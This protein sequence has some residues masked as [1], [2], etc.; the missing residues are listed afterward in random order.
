[1]PYPSGPLEDSTNTLFASM[2]V[3]RRALLSVSDKSGIVDFARQL[4]GLGVQLISTGG[5][6]RTLREA[7]LDVSDVSQIT[8]FP[9]MMDGRVKTLHPVIHGGLLARLDLATHV[10]AMK[11]YGIES[12]D[13]VVVNLYPFQQTLEKEGSTH[14]EIVEHID[15]GGPAM[16]RSSA[17][18]YLFTAIVTSPLRYESIL[19]ELRDGGMT[20]SDRTR[21]ELAAEAFTHTARYDSAISCYLNGLIDDGSLIGPSLAISLPRVQSLR[22]GENPHQDGGLY[23]SFNEIFDQIHG[24]ELSYNNILDIDAATRAVLEFD[25]PTV[26]IVKHTNPCGVARAASLLKAWELAFATDTKSPFGGIIAVNRSLDPD[27]ASAINEIFTEVVIA[28]EFPEET[29]AVLRR[30]RDR[31][32]I[33]ARYDRLRRSFGLEL[34]SVAGGVLAQSSDTRLFGDEGVRV[35]TKRKPG[36]DEMAAMEF[37]WRVAKHIKSNAIVYA[38]SD[39][40]L[41]IGAGQMS[42]VDSAVIAARKAAAAGLPLQ[43]CAVAS[44]AFFPFADGLLEAVEAGATAVIQPGGSVRDQEVIDAANTHNIAMVMTGMRH[45]RH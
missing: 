13:L 44:D 32:L 19:Q 38:L 16:V 43:G 26:V 5:T 1:M 45:F 28:P 25:E 8:G 29:L 21:L 12:I 2:H 42:R 23:G 40:T 34:R 20:I 3:V 33:T 4:S 37:A 35:V 18:N 24:K 14:D 39:R 31:R 10:D 7:G 30:K 41:G 9:E 27:T 6:A 17:K 36:E 22:Y 15:I 11:E